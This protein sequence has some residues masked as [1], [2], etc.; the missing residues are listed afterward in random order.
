MFQKIRTRLLLNNLLVFALVLTGAAIAVRLV[1]VKSLEAQAVERLIAVGR[2]VS[3]E[4]ELNDTGKLEIEDEFR[5]QALL[6]EHHSFE[7]F[8]LQGELVETIGDFPLQ[9]PLDTQA[10]SGFERVGEHELLFVVLPVMDDDT[11]DVLIGYI[12]V[13]QLPKA[14][15]EIVRQLDMG[16]GAGVVVAIALASIGILWLNRQAMKPI[17]ESFQRLKQ[18]TA[19]ASH[20]LRSPLMAISSNAEVSIKYSD[21]MR[22]SD[23]NAMMSILSASEQMAR[24]T[25]DLLSIARSD[26]IST[27]KLARLDLS[28]LLENLSKLYFSQ[29]A[30]KNIQIT[31]NIESDCW[32]QG[33]SGD[34]T[35]AFTNLLQNAI[36][37]TQ[38][39][40]RI[41]FSLRRY[42]DWLQIAI[43]DTGIGIAEEHLNR[44]F[45]RFWRADKARKYDGGA[46]GLGLSITQLII[47]RHGGS[48]AV[49]SSVGHGS[50]F[51]VSMP[52]A[53]KTSLP[54]SSS[55]S[56]TDL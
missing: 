28:S 26:Q 1:F 10:M 27:I 51:T 21:G 46:S 56:K 16:L 52:V 44:V 17:E 30:Q 53:L 18:F 20:E 3:D 5:V 4:A 31:T 15:E 55:V 29:A 37:Y 12:R 9:S 48:I 2:G 19:D 54:N 23:L 45:E 11:T 8:T 42:K 38:P 6:Y 33:D 32:A 39:G 43:E 24:L 34:L 36:R 41:D 47:Q 14:V 22:P 7:L 13:S 50:C 49:K 35:K 25:E 40:G